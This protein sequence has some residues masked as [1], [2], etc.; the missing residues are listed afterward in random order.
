MIPLV[1][2]YAYVEEPKPIFSIEKDGVRVEVMEATKIGMGNIDFTTRIVCSGFPVSDLKYVMVVPSIEG[3]NGEWFELNPYKL[4]PFEF[5]Q[6]KMVSADEVRVAQWT[7]KVRLSILA[8]PLSPEKI[9]MDAI[10]LQP[11]AIRTFI[12]RG[13]VMP[14]M[15]EEQVI[16]TLGKPTEINE[17]FVAGR[18]S[19]QWVYGLGNYVYFER[20]VVTAWQQRR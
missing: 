6:S 17:T 19:Q 7:G 4:A 5:T 13:V 3:R 16:L 9:R 2:L 14:K 8:A 18:K 15:T 1:A 20:G 10:A 11:K 12:E